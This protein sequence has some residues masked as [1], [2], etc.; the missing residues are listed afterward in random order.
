LIE[1]LNDRA[2]SAEDPQPQSV[3]WERMNLPIARGL[4][5]LLH[6]LW[7]LSQVDPSDLSIL[8]AGP[9][10]MRIGFAEIAAGDSGEPGDVEIA[11]A[12]RDCW[13]N[14]YCAFS[15]PVGTS[16]ICIHGDWSN[17]ADAKIKGGIAALAL[18]D[19]RGRPYNPL[20]ARAFRTPKPWGLTALFTE[21][22]G[23]HEPIALDW[24]VAAL[25]ASADTS[26]SPLWRPAP[27]AHAVSGP[28][29]SPT[30]D[31]ATTA[32]VG[33]ESGAEALMFETFWD[34]ARALARS[35]AWAMELAA[36]APP[37]DMAIEGE[38]VRK[39]LS[40][41]WV[42]SIF[43]LLS[44]AWRARLLDVLQR[45][46]EI[47]NHMMRLGRQQVR[48]ADMSHEQL[49]NI[50][51]NT[52]IT[53]PVGADMQLLIGVGNLWGPSSVGRL[54]FG[55]APPTDA[56]RIGSLLGLRG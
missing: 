39:L 24:T 53:G 15:R 21:Y 54:R 17:L 29:S 28:E 14:S 46:V 50:A 13:Q 22:T 26:H 42:K 16:L 9:G 31:N 35:D 40:T 33:R 4:R 44:D 51:A 12:V 55:E 2:Y 47:P 19:S 23:T 10:R 8:L 11:A 30:A 5:G 3:V 52:L 36:D 38:T 56:P 27:Q 20:Y 45:Q 48:L 37:P 7:D 25:G 34:F 32:S 43:P 41:L 6:V 18:N 1:I 49:K